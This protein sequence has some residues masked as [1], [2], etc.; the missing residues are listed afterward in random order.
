MITPNYHPVRLFIN[1][2]YKGVYIYLSQVNESLLRQH[3][4]MPGS[5]YFGDSA[6][7]NE[8][9]VRNLWDKAGF[10]VKKS[11]RNAEQKHNREDI[12][13]FIAA[14][15]QQDEKAFYDSFVN[16]FDQEKYN[17]FIAIDRIV[18]TSH[19]DYG[20]N[21]K[22]YFDPYKGK[23]EP[24]EWD[25]REWTAKKDK[26]ISA[27]PLLLRLK[28]N[29]ILDAEIDRKAFSILNAYNKDFFSNE[30]DRIIKDVWNDLSRD[31][32]KDN[33]IIN[34][35]ISSTWVSIPFTMKEYK[36]WMA[37]DKLLINKRI[38]ILQNLYESTTLSYSREKISNDK[39]LIKI[40]VDGEAPAT[41]ALGDNIELVGRLPWNLDSKPT[42]NI[43]L[44]PGRKFIKD[45]R[46][47]HSELLGRDDVINVPQYYEIIVKAEDPSSFKSLTATNYITG[48]PVT[49]KM[50]N[51][52]IEYDD[53]VIHPK[54]IINRKK[55]SVNFSGTVKITET[56]EFDEYT[57]VSISAG[58]TFHIDKGKSLFF[59]GKVVA[60]GTKEKPIKFMSAD[61]NKPWG[62]VAVHGKSTK[63]S[64]FN[65]VE[66]ENGSTDS[67]RLINYTA[68]F[69]IHDTDWFEV[70]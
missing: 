11:S 60:L 38:D 41:L 69:N 23:F 42:K 49:V 64:I 45:G 6:A 50:E 35:K 19:H 39:F 51:V 70:T 57:N 13:F 40:K 61:L 15:H 54:D 9:G 16:Y 22:V 46:E 53:A 18:G 62:I 12:N 52:I 8:R 36:S 47:R 24:I 48:K 67:H 2:D 68:P 56:L 37:I 20:H 21:H 26:D 3:K 4:V 31:H 27:N 58:T 7:L 10:W 17:T 33:A 5:I 30:M 43:R 34:H 66:F 28:N 63:G 44:Y 1:G 55:Q 59:Y 14:Q 65:Y 29:P 32:L 25:V